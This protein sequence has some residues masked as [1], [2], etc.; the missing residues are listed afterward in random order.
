[1]SVELQSVMKLT[2]DIPFDNIDDATVIIENLCSKHIAVLVTSK[3]TNIRQG[4]HEHDSYEFV[5]CYTK[6][7]SS[8]I[9]SRIFNRMRN[10]I[11]AVNPMQRHGLV[12]D[13]KGFNLCSIHADK[14]LIQGVA[15]DMYGSRD[16][17]FSNDSFVVNHDLS[18]LVRLFLEELR[19]K[20][21]GY[22]YLVENIGLLIAGNLMRQ[23]RHNLA[24][25]SQLPIQQ[26]EDAIKAVI[27]YMN[28]NYTTGVSCEELANI[29]KMNKFC[30][31]RSFKARTSKTPYEYLLD[32]KI[33]KAKK[34]LQVKNC[35]ITE[36]SMQ[37]GF[38]SHSHFT[39]TFK[40]RTGFSPTVYRLNI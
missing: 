31:I 28:E 22:E 36:I 3:D 23:I 18:M 39:S 21:T 37:C 5:I 26:N 35:S 10:T 16:I 11:F 1:M 40:K 38:S 9:D 4:T 29:V 15:G 32:L 25:K 30:F 14:E 33:D 6:L 17:E 20:Q 27:D 24:L 8:I 13:I 7:P 19:Y 2:G 12:N 34:M